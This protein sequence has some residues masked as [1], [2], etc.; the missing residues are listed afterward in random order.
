VKGTSAY[1]CPTLV[2]TNSF[3]GFVKNNINSQT[4]NLSLQKDF[5][6]SLTTSIQQKVNIKQ[7]DEVH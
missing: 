2:E 6:A 4:K 7:M 1:I 5:S 3:L